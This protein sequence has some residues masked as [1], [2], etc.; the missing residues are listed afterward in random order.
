MS[1]AMILDGVPNDLISNWNSL[2]IIIATPILTWGIYPWMARLG[3][4]LLPMTRMCIG[5]ML[6]CITCVICAL[7]QWRVYATSAC[8]KYASTCDTPSAISLWWQIPIYTIP[9]VGEL[10]VNVTS[11]E[12]AYTR[13]PARMKGLVYAFA[14]FNSAVAAA[15]GL[16]CSN[17]ITDPYLEWTWTA[18]AIASFLCAVSF[19]TYFKHL[20]TPSRDFADRDRQAGLSQPV[21]LSQDH[22]GPITL[23][24]YGD[25]NG[26]QYEDIDGKV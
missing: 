25:K 20:N 26:R 22:D 13:S 16:A 4:P 1:S 21:A 18:L 6:G 10:F 15:L 19:P 2:A 23:D 7:I 5:F 14:L 12:L 9:A 8:G 11:Y 24:Q 17:A 3:Y